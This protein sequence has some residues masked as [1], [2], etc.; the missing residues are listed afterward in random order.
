MSLTN[1]TSSLT[2]PFA[3]LQHHLLHSQYS[4]HYSKFW[5]FEL[6][7]SLET[8]KHCLRDLGKVFFS[9]GQSSVYTMSLPARMAAFQKTTTSEPM[10][11]ICPEKLL[12]F[13][14]IE[15]EHANERGR[16]SEE[17]LPCGKLTFQGSSW[18]HMLCCDCMSVI[19]GMR[20]KHTISTRASINELI[21]VRRTTLPT[22]QRT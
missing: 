3:K 22:S 15:T 11:A 18:G 16:R 8:Q 1:E 9:H 12:L 13:V 5:S 7:N 21:C 17:A 14:S 20:T 6:R 2:K 10:V 4:L 19:P